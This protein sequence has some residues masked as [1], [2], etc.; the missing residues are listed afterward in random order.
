[1]CPWLQVP[2]PSLFQ[3]L[4][5]YS[6]FALPPGLQL[7]DKNKRPHAVQENSHSK[8]RLV[9]PEGTQERS[10]EDWPA[11]EV[12]LKGVIPGSQIFTSSHRNGFSAN[13]LFLLPSL[14]CKNSIFSFPLASSEQFL[15]V[16]WD[17]VP[18]APVLISP[19]IKPNSQLPGCAFFS[20]PHMF[21]WVTLLY[22][23]SWRNIVNQL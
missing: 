13:L 12:Q 9:R 15:R 6:H 18:W 16:P 19:Q 10:Q 20:G 4:S 5:W 8:G 23:R 21:D 22:S 3:L 14:C 11:A 17:A 7:V 2:P 1:M